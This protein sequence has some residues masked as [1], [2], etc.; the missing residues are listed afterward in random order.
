MSSMMYRNGRSFFSFESPNKKRVALLSIS[1]YIESFIYPDVVQDRRIPSGLAPIPD[2]ITSY[3]FN[4]ASPSHDAISSQM[5]RLGLN[6][7]D[8]FALNAI[9]LTVEFVAGIAKSLILCLGSSASSYS[10]LLCWSFSE[11]RSFSSMYSGSSVTICH[12]SLY[13]RS[14]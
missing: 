2:F 5:Q 12:I 4:P 6:P 8:F 7:S 13:T 14:A 11:S 10:F 3:C 1:S 9:F